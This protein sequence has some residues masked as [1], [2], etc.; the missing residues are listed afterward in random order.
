MD[1]VGPDTG[2]VVGRLLC[3]RNRTAFCG[4]AFGAPVMGRVLGNR[5]VGRGCVRGL[6]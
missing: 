1:E 3:W 4:V 5:L 6:G 2:A